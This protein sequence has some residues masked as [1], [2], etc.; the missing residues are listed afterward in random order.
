MLS[1][2]TQPTLSATDA[3]ASRAVCR[4]SAVRW[5]ASIGA[6]A[7]A[8]VAFAA[9]LAGASDSASLRDGLLPAI[10]VVPGVIAGLLPL[11]VLAPRPAAAWAPVVLGAGMLRALVTLAAA[12][13]VFLAAGPDKIVFWAG[14][15]AAL[16]AALAAEVT[17][18]L[19]LNRR[20]EARP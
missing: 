14:V 5:G 16:L 19:A 10:A 4:P 6:A 13:A 1:V 12:V 11:A 3:P 17:L 2:T 20:A 18:T 8:G 7:A 9:G 15:L